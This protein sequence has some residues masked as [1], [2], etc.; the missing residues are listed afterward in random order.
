MIPA[1]VLHEMV[2]KGGIP[3]S[4]IY[5]SAVC[6]SH[7]DIG[8]GTIVLS[9]V[10]INPEVHIEQNFNLNTN[11]SIDHHCNLGNHVHICPVANFAGYV[12]VV[13]N[14]MI[15]TGVALLPGIT[16]SNNCIIPAGAVVI[17][18][19]AGYFVVVRNPAKLIWKL[20]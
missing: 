18:D 14:F 4:I 6:S 11:S 16:I 17:C 8:L 5:L 9:G 19:I 3:R 15:G 2:S 1:R 7:C 12:T 13:D 10:V 20:N